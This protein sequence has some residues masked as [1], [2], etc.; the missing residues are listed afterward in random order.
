VRRGWIKLHITCDVANHVITSVKITNENE[1]DGKQFSELVN[2]ARENVGKRGKIYG[3][4]L[5]TKG[6]TSMKLQGLVLS[7]SSSREL[8]PRA[9]LRDH[10]SG[11]R[12]SGSSFLILRCGRKGTGM[13]RGG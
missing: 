12:Q 7:Q 11:L 13:A 3:E 1:S 4:L 9:N 10:T 5:T 2:D 6:Q 8:I